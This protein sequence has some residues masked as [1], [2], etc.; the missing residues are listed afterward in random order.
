MAYDDALPGGAG[1][2]LATLEQT[3][4]NQYAVSDPARSAWVSANAGAGKTYV[5]IQRVTRLL[6]AG[7]APSRIVCITYTKAAAAEMASRLFGTLSRWALADDDALRA[8][9]AKVVGEDEARA[10]DLAPARLLFAR[11]LETPGGLKIQTIHSFCEMVL[12]RFPAEAGLLPGFTVLEDADA[13][14]LQREVIASLATDAVAEDPILLRALDT[15]G[16]VLR[17]DAGEG[18]FQ[19]GLHD[20]LAELAVRGRH[21]A[22]AHAAAGGLDGFCARLYAAHDLGAGD[23]EETVAARLQGALDL[24][25]LRQV[26]AAWSEGRTKA[27]GIAAAIT[28]AFEADWSLD[29]ALPVF[30]TKSGTPFAAGPGDKTARGLF[31]DFDARW[32]PMAAAAER[33]VAERQAIGFCA[34]NAALH[35]LAADVARRYDAAKATRGYLDFDDLIIRTRS[36]LADTSNAWV[37]YKLDQGIAHVLL[38]EAQDT[39]AEQWDVIW[40]LTEEFYAQESGEARTL[41][42]VGDEKQSIYSFQGADAALFQEKR[43]DQEKRATAAG[44]DRFVSRDFALSFRSTPPILSFVDAALRAGPEPL[45]PGLH[46]RHGSVSDGAHGS[47]E[48]WAPFQKDETEAGLPWDAPV[49]AMGAGDPHRQLAEAICERIKAWT[50][51]EEPLLHEERPV[52]PGDVMILFQRRAAAFHEMTQALSRHGI[53]TAGA[54]RVRLKEDVAVR[55]LIALMRFCANTGDCLSLA[56]LLKS[57]FWRLDD[58]ELLALAHG[59]TGSLW[60]TLRKAAADLPPSD[61]RAVAVREIEAALRVGRAEGAFALL[62]HILDASRDADGATGRRRIARRLGGVPKEAL[63]E[64]LG[65]ALAYEMRAPRSIEGFL[66][67]IE[68]DGGEVKKEQGEGAEAVRVMTVHGAKGLEAPIVILA[69]AT[70][71][72]EASHAFGKGSLLPFFGDEVGGIACCPGAKQRSTPFQAAVDEAD[73][74][75][76]AEYRRLFYVGATRAEQRLVVCGVETG[77]LAKVREGKAEAKPCEEADWHTLACRALDRLEGVQEV[78]GPHGAIRRYEAG[79][80]TPPKT[81]E[82]GATAAAGADAPSWLDLDGPQEAAARAMNPSRPGGAGEAGEAATDDPGPV[83]P[84]APDPEAP[85]YPPRPPANPNPYLRGTVIHALLER[86]PDIDEAERD[87]VG[88]VLAARYAAGGP[89]GAADA[90]LQEALGVLADARFAAVFGPGSRAEVPIVGRIAGQRWSGAI[91]RLVVTAEEI[92][93]VD[94]KSNRPPPA[95]PALVQPDYLRQLAAYAALV[96]RAHDGLPVRCALLW[97]YAPRL[98]EVPPALLEGAIG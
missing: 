11:A 73:Q 79:R 35:R 58:E 46:A 63:D 80:A 59:R 20:V 50:S 94:Y 96:Q 88:S 42:V 67:E 26:E 64:L 1:E 16:E 70:Y 72:K 60:Q 78:Q 91:D 41:F 82:G 36:L 71:C 95:D 61:Q 38:D 39:G 68:A 19:R 29:A 74:R 97:T 65:A 24:A 21:V 33:A 6:L 40:Q 83:D 53:P 34:F 86:L 47:V 28:E 31:A 14:A 18:G 52:R 13:R 8:A 89:P 10:A 17:P 54:D 27:A 48:V 22:S 75:R 2:D 90:W 15:A 25:F 3:T 12:R 98:M 44:E 30:L 37:L 93:I 66:A 32:A 81:S 51:G 92:L 45:V 5:L 62:T 57:P 85:A 56:E 43:A 23:T 49:D 84:D 55:D 77:P 76:H 87:Q 4:D 9:L 69:D 7:C